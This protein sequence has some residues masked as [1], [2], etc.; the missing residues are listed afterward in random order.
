MTIQRIESLTYGAEDVAAGTRYFEDWGLETVEKGPAGAIFRT[1]ENQTIHLR[2]AG[3]P[4]LPP[5]PLGG[6]AV[7]RTT[8][9]VDSRESLEAIGAELEKDRAVG[10][11]PDGTIN[12]AD[13]TGF[14]IAFRLSDRTPARPDAQP[15]NLN[16][17]VSRI[18]IP[19]DPDQRARPIR[20]GHVVFNIP[21]AGAEEAS[22]FYIDRL[23]FRLS[24]RARDTGD[25]MRCEG[26]NDHHTLFLAHRQNVTGFNHTAFEVRNFDE[27]MLGGKNMKSRGWEANSKPGRHIMGSNLFWYFR[28]PAGGATEYFADMDRMDDNW[29]PRIW[30][31]NPGY[32]MW[33]LDD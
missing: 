2:S 9:G 19:V 6:S 29:E 4:E 5:S 12:A 25:F 31:T 13:E 20:I 33:T 8:W 14:A 22:K 27:I 32:A 7:Y 18:N 15:V 16:D 1:P 17:D 10:A 23:G 30:D 24:D 11:D 26:S 3:D 21:K 28:N